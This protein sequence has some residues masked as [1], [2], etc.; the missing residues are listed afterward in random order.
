LQQLFSP[1]QKYLA[2]SQFAPYLAGMS[3]QEMILAI[4]KRGKRVDLSPRQLA[5]KVNINPATWWRIKTGKNAP[6][7]DTWTRLQKLHAD[8]APSRLP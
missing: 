3:P 5:E 2:F 1:R 8:L 7:F 4:E 6:Q